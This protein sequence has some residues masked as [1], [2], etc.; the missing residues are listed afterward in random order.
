MLGLR[1]FQRCRKAPSDGRQEGAA[2]FLPLGDLD[3]DALLVQLA[4]A[5]LGNIGNNRDLRGDRPLVDV[6]L[7]D[8]RLEVLLQA[9]VRESEIN[10]KGKARKLWDIEEG[11]GI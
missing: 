4:D 8:E 6:A 1:A 9:P 5:G 11:K 10:Q 7:L 2:S 3:T